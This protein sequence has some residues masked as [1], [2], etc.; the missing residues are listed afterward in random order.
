MSRQ[1]P[2]PDIR[3]CDDCGGLYDLARMEYYGPK[4]PN[5]RGDGDGG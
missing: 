1:P 5:C 2:D 4:C 3:I